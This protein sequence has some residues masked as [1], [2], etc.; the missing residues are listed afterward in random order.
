MLNQSRLVAYFL[1]D[2]TGEKYTSCHK[3]LHPLNR[4]PYQVTSVQ[5]QNSLLMK[6]VKNTPPFKLELN[7]A[8]QLKRFN[9]CNWFLNKIA[10]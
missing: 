4:R 7:E 8:D 3:T 6:L 2:E 1:I 5:Q 9:S 10:E